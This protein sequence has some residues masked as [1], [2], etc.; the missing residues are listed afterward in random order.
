MRARKA[1][2]IVGLSAVL[3]GAVQAET[4]E[5]SAEIDQLL[6]TAEKLDVGQTDVTRRLIKIGQPAYDEV[7]RRLR[8]TGD[9]TQQDLLLELLY[10]ANANAKSYGD[11]KPQLSQ[12]DIDRLIELMGTDAIGVR[13]GAALGCGEQGPACAAGAGAMLGVMGAAS[14]ELD[15]VLARHELAVALR[16]LGPEALPPVIDRFRETSD[17]GLLKDLAY[18]LQGRELPDDMRQKLDTL[19]KG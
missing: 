2:L 1:A 3:C 4:P 15:Y 8:E 16:N 7:L 14:T 12:A 10:Q 19:P 9:A 17:P 13:V 5:I 18:V 11:P 6:A